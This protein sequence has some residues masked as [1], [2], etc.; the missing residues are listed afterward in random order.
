[1]SKTGFS[2]MIRAIKERPFYLLMYS[3]RTLLFFVNYLLLWLQ[4]KIQPNF[5]IGSNPRILT[6]NVFKAE[7]PHSQISVGDSIIVY[8][9]CD[10]LVT[11]NGQLT[12]GNYCIIGS[13]FRLYCKEKIVLGNSVLISWNVLITDYDAHAIDPHTRY[14]EIL[15]LQK[16]F[17]PSFAFTDLP[18]IENFQPSYITRP[19]VIED[20]VWIGANAMIL[21]GVHIGSSSIVAAGAVVTNDVPERCVVAGNPARVV[22][23]IN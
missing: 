11:G 10:I 19:V 2:L 17:H 23:V 4:R 5:S 13:N 6:T 9:N 15:Y 22:K 18:L 1:M 7:M 3:N 14:Q 12:I 8:N 20:N 21:K 16:N